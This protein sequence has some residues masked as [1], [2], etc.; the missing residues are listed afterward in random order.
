MRARNKC[1]ACSVEL[2]SNCYDKDGYDI[3][4]CKECGTM[5]VYDVPDASEL[6]KIYASE[7]YY[8]IPYAHVLRIEKE[9]QRRLK[10][11]K[12]FKSKGK[13]LDIG[14]A[15]GLL[16]DKFIGSG[17]DTYGIELSSK[18]VKICLENKHNVFHGYLDDYITRAP[19]G[20]FDVITCLDVIEHVDDPD[21]FLMAAVSMLN[22]DGV[23]VVSTPNY[24][25]LVAKLLKNRDPFMT[26][27]EHLNYF[28]LLGMCKL[29]KKNKLNINKRVTF[30]YLVEDELNRVISKYA[31]SYFRY[32]ESFIRPVIPFGMRL[33]N[34]FKI[35]VEQEF[36]LKKIK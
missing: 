14:C 2:T 28:T 29:F 18:N 33:L 11:I 17:F 27:P 7:S 8:E 21:T 26:P 12:K 6:T 16:L 13:I 23:I 20:G 22:E 10:I 31:P 25:G 4:K 5:F 19:E 35:G 34:V 9:N 15:K 1:P 32:L 30:G 24:S 3:W 36:Y